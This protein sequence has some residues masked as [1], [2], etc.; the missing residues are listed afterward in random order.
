MSETITFQSQLIEVAMEI[1][2]AQ[3]TRALKTM[4][5]TDGE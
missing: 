2:I 1:S 3:A 5:V 4:G